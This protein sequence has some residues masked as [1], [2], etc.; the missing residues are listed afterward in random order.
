LS[1]FAVSFLFKKQTN[2]NMIDKAVE[3]VRKSFKDKKDKGGDEYVNHLFRVSQKFEG[4]DNIVVALLHD[5]LED[6]EEWNEEML[7]KEFN[8]DVCDAV[9]CLTKL[10]NDPGILARIGSI[11]FRVKVY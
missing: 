2:N 9:V 8:S 5:L 3:I 11:F 7:R 6:C 1:L 10:P 4:T